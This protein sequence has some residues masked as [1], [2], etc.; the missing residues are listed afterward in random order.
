MECY[1]CPTF[2]EHLSTLKAFTGNFPI[3][4]A[5]T[6]H[7]HLIDLLASRLSISSAVISICFVT[8]LHKKKGRHIARNNIIPT[9]LSL[10][11]HLNSMTMESKKRTLRNVQLQML[12]WKFNIFNIESFRLNKLLR[13]KLIQTLLVSK[14]HKSKKGKMLQPAFDIQNAF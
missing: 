1:H 11:P 10:Q 13:P 6:S 2:L 12:R 7:Q 8:E 9:D 14:R 5:E 4:P 3:F